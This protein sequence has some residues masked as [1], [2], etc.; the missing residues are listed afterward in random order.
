MN[1]EDYIPL[2]YAYNTYNSDLFTFLRCAPSLPY[3]DN[4]SDV[5]RLR[6]SVCRGR[7]RGRLNTRHALLKQEESA[8]TGECIACIYIVRV[9]SPDFP[10]FGWSLGMHE[11]LKLK[12]N[13]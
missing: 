12:T 10:P 2:I 4:A 5:I 7:G 1:S 8:A 6:K 9:N 3:K 13:L 11:T